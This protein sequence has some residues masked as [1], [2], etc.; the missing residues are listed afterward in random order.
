MQQQNKVRKNF[1]QRIQDSIRKYPVTWVLQVVVAAFIILPMFI[2]GSWPGLLIGLFAY[3]I[4]SILIR[5]EFVLDYRRRPNTTS[6]SILFWFFALQV[7]LLILGLAYTDITNPRVQS[8]LAKILDALMIVGMIGI[9]G[10]RLF[11]KQI[12][13]MNKHLSPKSR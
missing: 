11:S 8:G 1:L 7:S 13:S 9:W 10:I 4:V 12:A 6:W 3:S 2:L 5:T